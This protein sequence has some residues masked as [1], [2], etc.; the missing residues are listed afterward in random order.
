MKEIICARC[1]NTLEKGTA[2]CPFCGN[3]LEENTALDPELTAALAAFEEKNR[4]EAQRA[5]ARHQAPTT[6]KPAQAGRE[7]QTPRPDGAQPKKARTRQPERQCPTCG[8][9]LPK[10]LKTC[11]FCRPEQAEQPKVETAPVKKSRLPKILGAAALAVLVLGGVW[12][13]VRNRTP[14]P[15]EPTAL[16]RDTSETPTQTMSPPETT[17]P[18]TET[19]E[20]GL[21][22]EEAQTLA[23]QTYN[24]QAE[25]RE[26]T[27]AGYTF[28]CLRGSIELGTVLVDRDGGVRVL[29]GMEQSP[30]G[31]LD[32]AHV[33]SLL[34]G[35]STAAAYS[36]CLV[37]TATGESFGSENRDTGLSA[38]A[39]VDLPILYAVAKKVEAGELSMDS[40]ITVSTTS[41]G[42]GSLAGYYGAQFTLAEMLDFVLAR[43]SNDAS[44]SLMDHI[45]IDVINS[46]CHEAGFESVRLTNHIGS[47]VENTDSDNYISAHDAA[48]IVD[49]LF[50]ADG[51]IDG[52][53]LTEHMR[54]A[55]GDRNANRGLGRRIGEAMIG[56]HNGSTAYKYNEVIL[57]RAGGRTYAL[58]FMANG[59]D[60][61]WLQSAAAEI[62]EYCQSIMEQ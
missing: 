36:W 4:N 29:D 37:D 34:R 59:A 6:P 38:S 50:R 3:D 30:G 15:T 25:L 45:G 41:N 57:A 55:D 16:Q 17:E 21:S 48:A 47:T 44:N 9:T 24:C 54:I 56:N 62:G 26:Q 46:L 12:L 49:T 14:E 23:A 53:Y 60:A 11:P 8:R 52:A 32:A 22:A 31:A 5:L 42:R 35:H 7:I 58:C 20:P 40:P 19:T 1:G 2:V 13:A 18:P 33:E 43:S 28:A 51:A 27:E 61:T 39:L 10:G